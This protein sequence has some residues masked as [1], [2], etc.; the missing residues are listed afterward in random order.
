MTRPRFLFLFSD[1]GGGHRSTAEAVRDAVESIPGFEAE[2]VLVD[3]LSDY[4]PPPFNRL[5]MT[6]PDL[7]K[8]PR[9]WAFFYRLSNGP[10]R[11]RSI[12]RLTWPYVR[13]AAGRIVL[14]HPADVFVSFH[15]IA[16][17]PF[18][19]ALNRIPH[20]ERPPYIVVVTDLVSTHAFWFHRGADLTIVPTRPAYRHALACGLPAERVAE[21]GLPVAERFCRPD[22]EREVLRAALGW[23]ADRKMVLLVGGGEGM[24]PLEATARSIARALPEV[25]LAVVAGRNVALQARLEKADWEIPTFTYGFV[26]NMPDLMAAADVLVTKAGPGTISEGLNA[27]LPIILYSFLPGQEAGNVPY[28][29]E[30]GA[31]LWAPSPEDVIAGLRGWLEDQEAYEAARS[32]ARRLARPD[33]AR[34]IA[35]LLLRV[36]DNPYP[37]LSG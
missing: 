23:P 4:A 22:G 8:R 26:R 27:G 16:N 20:P 9:G 12:G 6:Y 25:G 13:R 5:P 21:V 17:D 32:A 1:T 31:G 36:A 37:F 35:A 33:A 15:P 3:F 24:G 34:E 10:G 19:R 18:V 28:L 11:V 30:N 14:N 2:V 29:T 7:V